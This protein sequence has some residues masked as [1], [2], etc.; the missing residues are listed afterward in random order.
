MKL[1]LSPLAA[2]VLG[3]GL[4]I[5][6]AGAGAAQ[7]NAEAQITG[8]ASSPYLDVT[9]NQ[10]SGGTGWSY[11]SV[12]NLLIGSSPASTHAD[13]YAV[14]GTG[15]L[16]MGAYTNSD[17]IGG[18]SFTYG[19]ATASGS[20]ADQFVF[21]SPFATAGSS[22]FATVALDIS[23]SL[24]QSFWGPNAS[25]NWLWG[26]S[27]ADWRAGIVVNGVAWEGFQHVDMTNGVENGY[28]NAAPGTYLFN[29][30]VVFGNAMDLYLYAS[31]QANSSVSNSYGASNTDQI[32]AMGHAS[33]GNTFAW[34]GVTELRDAN[35]VLITDFTA[36][37]AT[38]GFDYANAYV[39]AVPVPAAAWLM[40][41]GLLGLVGVARRKTA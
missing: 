14:I 22:G 39:S 2:L 18:N 13:A 17:L 23:G 28:G 40:G 38:S 29:I 33:F 34:G 35:G 25:G 37:S 24:L 12:N 9:E 41:S 16:H 30:P 11:A 26:R 32:I 4:S 7:Y 3:A 27:S 20:F 31:V 8:R 19:Q 10:S 36:V 1:T 15:G 6:T 21:S 5:V